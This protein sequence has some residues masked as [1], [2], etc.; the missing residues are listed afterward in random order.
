MFGIKSISLGSALFAAAVFS[1]LA[2]ADFYYNYHPQAERQFLGCEITPVAGADIGLSYTQDVIDLK[3][4]SS[5]S[6][7]F[8]IGAEIAQITDVRFGYSHLG[9]YKLNS[10]LKYN[11]DTY[12]IDLRVKA[13]VSAEYKLYGGVG[14]AKTHSKESG[15][16]GGKS[17][18]RSAFKGIA[19][20]EKRAGKGALTFEVNHYSRVPT[21]SQ[22]LYGNSQSA[23]VTAFKLGYKHKF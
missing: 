18:N 19:G 21:Y 1:P 17:D 5:F 15:V 22:S 11:F 12:D 20:I 4:S 3:S 8:F 6:G 16:G 10:G 9:Q 7:G 2:Q 23:G 13:P 14:L